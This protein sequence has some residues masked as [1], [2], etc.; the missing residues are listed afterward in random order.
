MRK[1]WENSEE[2]CA[3]F[4]P[5]PS[6]RE[7]CREEIINHLL[8]FPIMSLLQPSSYRQVV[9]TATEKDP[10][11][12]Y[13]QG[14]GTYKHFLFSSIWLYYLSDKGHFLTSSNDSPISL[15]LFFGGLKFSV[16]ASLLSVTSLFLRFLD[17]L[18]SWTREV[19]EVHFTVMT[20]LYGMAHSHSGR[21][22]ILRKQYQM[23]ESL[24]TIYR[25]LD[26]PRVLTGSH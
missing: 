25:E 14:P 22:S 6:T 16:R 15:I 7:K 9:E 8:S 21:I 10:R 24:S 3:L 26:K 4:R 5:P 13:L 19:K 2:N 18:T 1:Q 17:L 11:M 23:R 20:S 12:A